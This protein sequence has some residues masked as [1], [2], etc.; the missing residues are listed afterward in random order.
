MFC[1]GKFHLRNIKNVR[2][3]NNEN[4]FQ[5]MCL[6]TYVCIKRFYFECLLAGNIMG[7]SGPMVIA[8]QLFARFKLFSK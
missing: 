6:K 7:Q 5:S 3:E 1:A 4:K 8:I 2:I